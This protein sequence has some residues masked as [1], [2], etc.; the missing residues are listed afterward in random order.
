MRISTLHRSSPGQSPEA[1]GLDLE[2]H[3]RHL[4]RLDQSMIELGDQ[5]AAFSNKVDQLVP[6]SLAQKSSVKLVYSTAQVAE[7]FQVNR[8]TVERWIRRGFVKA[9]KLTGSGPRGRWFILGEHVLSLLEPCDIP[10]DS[11]A[12][13]LDSKAPLPG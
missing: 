11:I 2:N 12:S 10:T 9:S 6:A 3:F 13:R 4:N 7:L 8:K 1:E 5:L